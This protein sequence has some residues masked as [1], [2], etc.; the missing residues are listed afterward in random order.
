LGFLRS[1]ETPDQFGRFPKQI[2]MAV[3]NHAFLRHLARKIPETMEL[4]SV[5][6]VTMLPIGPRDFDSS[7]L[8]PFTKD[9]FEEGSIDVY[10]STAHSAIIPTDSIGPSPSQMIS[11]AAE[12]NS[13]SPVI[14]S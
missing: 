13:S 5:S 6:L 9:P 3:Q 2:A 14:Q 4:P 1:L 8:I 12:E 7:L 11:T 10:Y